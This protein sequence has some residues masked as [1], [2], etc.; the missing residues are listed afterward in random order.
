MIGRMA[1]LASTNPAVTQA[2]DYVFRACF[3]DAFQGEVMSKF[4][5]NTLKAKRAAIR[6]VLLASAEHRFRHA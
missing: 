4:A 2:G 1:I 3:I 5:V 6:L